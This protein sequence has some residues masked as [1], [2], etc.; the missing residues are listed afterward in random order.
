[1][2]ILMSIYI[3]VLVFFPN[4]AEPLNNNSLSEPLKN[5]WELIEKQRAI[6]AIN[7][8]SRFSPDKDSLAPYHYIHAKAYAQMNRIHDAMEHFRLAFIYSQENSGKE[9]ILFDRANTYVNNKYYDE[10]AVCFRIFVRLFPE[11]KLSEQ[12]YLGL[13]ESLYNIGRF[14]DAFIFFQKSGNSF[15]A[16]YGKADTLHAMGRINE[17]HE[18][19]QYLI[20]N[21]KGY[22]KSQ[23]NSYNIG[24]NFRLMNK[25]SFAKVY[26]ALVKDYPLKYKAELSSGLIAAD[27]GQ[28]DAAMRHFELALQSPDRTVKRKSL[29][30][31]SE[32]LIKTGKTQEAKARLIEI[33]NKYP[34]GKDY[35]EALRKL[36]GMYKN[37]GG[38]HNAASVLRELVFRKNP[39]KAALDEFEIILLE[40][41]KKN[42]QDFI[43]LWKTVGQWLLE[44]SRSHFILNI[45]RDLK[46]AGKAYFGVCKWLSKHGSEEAKMQGNLLL[47]EFYAE[48]GDAGTS[49][50]YA[51]NVKAASKHEDMSRINAR[52]FYLKGE[53]EK[54]LTT[55][56]QIKNLKDGDVSLFIDISSE[57]PPTA[58]NHQNLISFLGNA[59]KSIE[60]KPKF[61][62]ELADVL[63]QMG[64]GQDA[65]KQYKAAIAVNEKNKSLTAK[66]ADWCLYRISILTV[67]NESDDAVKELQKGKDAINRF[68]G[69]KSKETSLNERLK[70]LF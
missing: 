35:D 55:L 34:Y 43:S 13:A 65:L 61:N 33:R 32:V 47:A 12:A 26:L 10:A 68:A 39:D 6:D 48:M 21:D 52:L 58:K 16:L 9:Q 15:K 30:Y 44:P 7:A 8:L 1:M 53:H 11:S 19:Y 37:E 31:L 54:A 17:A 25:L 18:Q 62:I 59:L 2:K 60:D 63:Y 3:L 27:E 56:S 42:N 66:D 51:R 24:E 67:K 23:L 28:V 36:A 4:A 69:A 41:R 5:A 20:K 46:P 29:L 22:I 57:M 64:K 49:S 70:G 50:K 45:V 38:F 40:A 14:N